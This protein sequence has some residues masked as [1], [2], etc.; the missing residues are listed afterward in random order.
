MTE[1]N[2]LVQGPILFPINNIENKGFNSCSQILTADMPLNI[3]SDL[4]AADLDIRTIYPVSDADLFRLFLNEEASS[5]S[6]S[7]S[8]ESPIDSTSSEGSPVRSEG[9]SSSSSNRSSSLSFDPL[10]HSSQESPFYVSAISSSN[11]SPEQSSLSVPIIRSNNDNVELNPSKNISVNTKPRLN[12]QLQSLPITPSPPIPPPTTEFS[13]KR[14]R[15]S[16]L[17]TL[18]TNSFHSIPLFRENLE[19]R[20]LSNNRVGMTMNNPTSC[21]MVMS[22]EEIRLQKQRRL[23]KNRK[24]AQLSRLRKKLYFEDLEKK[25]SILSAENEV[26]VKQLEFIISDRDR[27]QQEVSYLQRVL[28]EN[29]DLRVSSSLESNS[30]SNSHSS[31]V[32]NL[33]SSSWEM[34]PSQ[35]VPE[36][37]LLVPSPKNIKAAGVC[38]LIVM[39]SFG[40]FF[41]TLTDQNRFLP[42]TLLDS[43]DLISRNSKTALYSFGRS[44]KSMKEE[45]STSDLLSNKQQH[46]KLLPSGSEEESK[47]LQGKGP[48]NTSIAMAISRLNSSDPNGT[49]NNLSSTSTD[50]S[51]SS[52]VGDSPSFSRQSKES[53][54]PSENSRKRKMKIAE[55]ENLQSESSDTAYVG[56]VSLLHE[57]SSVSSNSKDLISLEFPPSLH[58]G[59]TPPNH[60][61]ERVQSLAHQLRDHSSSSS[62]STY[63]YCPQAQRLT[64]WSTNP[65]IGASSERVALLIPTSVLNATARGLPLDASLLEVSCQVLNYYIW[66]AVSSSDSS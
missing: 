7:S 15:S 25:V 54:V 65:N 5:P 1:S 57:R 21:R 37:R 31:T 63:L 41:N 58:S 35:T 55:E 19:L 60:T 64:P 33:S 3:S 50:S 11:S 66:P 45:D 46:I 2:N 8:D 43:D 14:E 34:P 16:N 51:I 20:K 4:G 27:L 62:S 30:V 12:S 61:L 28:K 44:L 39:L 48:S 22:E 40:L 26:L 18:P 29:G 17:S 53:R 56:A 6:P 24:S 38:L 59:K 36:R 42:S 13:R 9:C 52:S 23:V 32:S 47:E 10:F 49:R